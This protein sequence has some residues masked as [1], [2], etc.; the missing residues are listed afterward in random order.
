MRAKVLHNVQSSALQI[1]FSRIVPQSQSS[2]PTLLLLASG[3]QPLLLKSANYPP[4]LQLPHKPVHTKSPELRSDFFSSFSCHPIRIYWLI[5]TR[6]DCC[7]DNGPGGSQGGYTL[8]SVFSQLLWLLLLHFHSLLQEQTKPSPLRIQFASTWSSLLH[9]SRL[10]VAAMHS[11]SPQIFQDLYSGSQSFRSIFSL[12]YR[13]RTLQAFHARRGSQNRIRFRVG[14]SCFP[15]VCLT[16][17]MSR[18]RGPTASM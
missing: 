3:I 18:P 1:I 4:P 13:I 10:A 2:S 9:I 5:L 14:F 15:S 7:T 8:F 6:N 16:W 11:L 17:S 12:V